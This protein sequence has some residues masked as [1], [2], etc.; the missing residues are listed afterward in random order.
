MSLREA[1]CPDV[2]IT[3]EIQAAL[4]QDEAPNR[5]ESLQAA[6]DAYYADCAA[7]G[8]KPNDGVFHA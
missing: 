5:R 8:V 4:D 2:A 6:W 1:L 3:P 7:K